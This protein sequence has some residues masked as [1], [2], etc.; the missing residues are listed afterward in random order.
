[1]M[2]RTFFNTLYII[3]YFQNSSISIWRFLVSCEFEKDFPILCAESPPADLSRSLFFQKISK[4]L[5]CMQTSLV[6]KKT[7]PLCFS[8]YY[9]ECV[10][11]RSGDPSSSSVV[12]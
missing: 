3:K 11:S 7:L 8:S 6:T 10:V 2:M 4:N 1:M 5:F 12:E 9:S